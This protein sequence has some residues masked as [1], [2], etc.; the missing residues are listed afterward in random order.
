MAHCMS[1]S[2][3][4]VVRVCGRVFAVNASSCHD[5]QL[6]LDDGGR[7]TLHEEPAQEP[8]VLDARA[9]QWR[10]GVGQTPLR[11]ELP[12]GRVFE[13]QAFGAADQL[14][15]RLY[16][17][18]PRRWLHRL[19]SMRARNVIGAFFLIMGL[20]AASIYWGLPW[21]ANKS[22]RFVPIA[23]EERIGVGVLE[24]LD[25]TMMDD[26]TLPENTRQEIQ[27]VFNDLL[28]RQPAPAYDFQLHVRRSA[29]LGA[30]AL[31]LPGGLVV[32]T[33]DLIKLAANNDEIAGVLAHELGHVRHRHGLRGLARASSLS[34]VLLFVLGDGASILNDAAAFGAL[35]LQLSYSR[36]FER[37]ADAHAV[38]L[39][40]ATG[41][42]PLAL[43][44]VL[45][46]LQAQ[47]RRHDR[48]ASADEDLRASWLST[49]PATGERM[50]AIRAQAMGAQ[51]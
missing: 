29:R 50:A 5:A 1:D 9:L 41:R 39:M 42:D 45:E 3:A 28:T 7:L 12:D 33:D 44:H 34:F 30:N 16:R 43:A 13:T 48:D 10:E 49:H 6:H 24:T 19:E 38:A 35:F 15:K 40:R 31:A 4:T 46:R 36:A 37:E 22:V 8:A 27:A 18:A 21:L 14:R 17:R 11:V 2:T 47:H 23:W 51:P 32:I 25:A 26:S 20:A